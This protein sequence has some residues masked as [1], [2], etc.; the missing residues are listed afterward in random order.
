MDEMG[1][2]EGSGKGGR[3]GKKRESRGGK[4]KDP[5]FLPTLPGVKSHKHCLWVVSPRKLQLR[6]YISKKK[7]ALIYRKDKI[8]RKIEFKLQ[9]L[10]S[11]CTGSH[12][13]K[14]GGPR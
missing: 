3:M 5:R 4:V 1:Y 9:H 11:N 14:T 12:Q 13:Q 7:F 10:M 6:I 2:R 8:M